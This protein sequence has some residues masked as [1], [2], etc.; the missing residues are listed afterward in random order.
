[1]PYLDALHTLEANKAV[2][3]DTHSFFFVQCGLSGHFP[4]IPAE[5]VSFLNCVSSINVPT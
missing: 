3:F 2:I 5:T 4:G 1:M